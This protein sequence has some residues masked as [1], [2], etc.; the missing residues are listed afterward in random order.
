MLIDPVLLFLPLI[1]AGVGL[2]L[3]V[4]GKKQERWPHLVAG[5]AFMVYPYFTNSMWSLL[6]TGAALTAALWYVVRLGW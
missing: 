4:Y 5:V 1:P 2:V 3:F 6:L